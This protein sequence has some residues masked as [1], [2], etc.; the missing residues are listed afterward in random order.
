M[1]GWVLGIES[2][3]DRIAGLITRK[4]SCIARNGSEYLKSGRFALLMQVRYLQAS[5]DPAEGAYT[6]VA[7]G[8]HGRELGS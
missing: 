6:F 5:D 3:L 7:A 8:N 2:V 4:R 1:R